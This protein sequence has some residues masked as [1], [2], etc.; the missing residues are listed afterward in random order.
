VPVAGLPNVHLLGEKPYA[1]L[2]GYVN[3]FDVC[4][5]PFKITPLTEAT[6]PVK[7][8]EHMASG[9]PVVSTRL[10]ELVPYAEGHV[11]L[12]DTADELVR[13][14]EAALSDVSPA[15][16][17]RRRRLARENT[18]EA[19]FRTLD[20]AIRGLYPR[21]SLI[22]LTFN[23]LA[24][25][26]LCI[27]SILRN[28]LRPDYELIVVDNASKDGTPDYLR[29]LAKV[30][31]QIKLILN[32]S[33]RGFAGGN[34]QGIRAATGEYVVL[35]NNDTVLPRGWLGRLL[36]HLE[37]D[38]KV[39]LVGPVTTGAANEAYVATQ[40]KTLAAMEAF[41]ARQF[42]AHAGE[43]FP[44]AVP[45]LFCAAARRALFD[46]VGLLDERYE[47]GLFE[48]DDLAVRVRRAGYRTLCARDVFVHHFQCE[49]FK[50]F[51]DK[52]YLKLFN[53]N[54]ERF[55]RKWNVTWEQHRRG[56][57]A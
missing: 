25:N 52:G 54:R 42:H 23:N 9:K 1:T 33:N 46:E 10:P 44:L 38:P 22:V 48:D 18:W 6:N 5:I 56:E 26:R 57:A 43:T 24:I 32:E 30:Y 45:A 27:E 50:Q 2:P 28:T 15:A 14:V 4:L 12:G 55:E 39:G 40:Y 53:A 13:G 7:F 35:L 21:A 3:G 8:Y 51:G 11:T 19:R 20:G 17:A 37:R 49:G 16:V 31:P 41:A 34:N 36:R 47:I 29:S